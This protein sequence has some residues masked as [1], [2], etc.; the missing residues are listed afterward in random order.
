LS[1]RFDDRSLKT[2]IKSI[3]ASN[4]S[5]GNDKLNEASGSNHSRAIDNGVANTIK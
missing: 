4:G 2:R 3:S 5:E 1:K